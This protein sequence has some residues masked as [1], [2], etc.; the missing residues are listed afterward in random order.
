[1]SEINKGPEFWMSLEHADAINSGDA[2]QLSAFANRAESEFLSS[3][4]ASEDGKDGFARRE[5]LKLMGASIALATTACVRRPVQHIIPYAKAPKDVT[6]GV[7]NLYA[8]TWYDGIEGYGAIVRTLEGRPIKMEGNPLHPMNLGAFPARGHAE[9]LSLYD[10]DRLT[11]PVRNL[12]NKT[13]SNRE[14]ISGA[15]ADIDTKIAAALGKGSVAIL[16]STLPSP[17]TRAIISDFS[18]VFPGTRWVQYDTL[19]MDSVRE[20][21][22]L[23]YGRAVVPRYRLDQAKMIVSIDADILGSYLSPV[24][25]MKQWAKIRKP[26]PDQARFVM[27]DS[28]MSLSGMNADDRV[29]IKPS[30]QLDVVMGLL[31][32][33]SRIG[34]G[35]GIP[36]AAATYLKGFSGVATQLGMEPELFTKIA[37]QLWDNR[38][39]SLVIAGG[40]PTQTEN[41]VDLQVAVNLLNS[42]LGN[43]GKTIDHDSANYMTREGSAQDLA[44]LIADMAAGKIKTLIIHNLN[45]VYSLPKDSGFVEAIAKV[46]TVISTANRNDET[47]KYANFVLPNGSTL[48]SWGDYELQAGVY[49]IQQPT[50]RPLHD[51]RSFDESMFAWVKAA[52]GAP[53]RVASSETWMDYVKGV[54]RTEILPKAGKGTGDEAWF[55]VL[56]TGVVV[57]GNR[58]RGGSARGFSAGS[59]N[60]KARKAAS[61]YELV[62]YP[63]SQIGD[64]RYANVAW[65]Q[66]MPDPV[67]KIVWDNYVSIAP[68]TADKE[69]LKQGDVVEL[70]V[71]DKK[72]R[73]PVHVQPGQ[74]EDVFA[75]AIGYGRTDAGR[76]ASGLGVNALD[77]VSFGAGK[78][79]YSG[80]PVTFKKTGERYRL[81]STQDHH[82]LTPD[83]ASRQLVAE[84]T[85]TAYQK[86]PGSG[87][88][89]HKVFSI[90]PS[91]QYSKHKWAMSIDLNTCTGCS[92]CVVAC[93]S[94]N[95]VPVVGKKYVMEGREMHWLRIDRYY[96]GSVNAPEAVFQ[97][98]L[99]QHCE[100][101]PCETVCPVLATV[102]NDEG[103]NDMVYNR[104]VGTRYCSNNC[105]YKV[106]RFNWFNYSKREAPMHMALNPD[107]TVRTRG[108]MEKCTFCVHRIREATRAGV[109][110]RKGGPLKDGH[111]KT[112]CQETCPADAIVFGDLNDKESAVAKLFADQRTYGLLEDLNTAPRVRYMSRVRNADR[113][114]VDSHAT[115]ENEEH[116]AEHKQPAGQG[117]SHSERAGGGETHSAEQN[118]AGATAAGKSET[119]KQPEHAAEGGH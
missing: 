103:L 93:Q 13:R 84:T 7:Q 74:H 38:G 81:V 94:E 61:G 14:T 110:T 10:P 62:L 98:M 2:A 51:S 25:F 31:A 30:Q 75:L 88:H 40:L 58:D 106:R 92:A 29:R 91:H 72:V 1:M 87:I 47:A 50:I 102:H 8:S 89:R 112:A 27:F 18:R 3:P 53:A 108:V 107:V 86:N 11:G 119:N 117:E 90:W 78:Q 42:V 99:C 63:K 39:A 77:L 35:A 76:V 97:P 66:E 70:K 43:D 16:S 83:I 111:L 45:P 79:V 21:Q 64:G 96:K 59:F 41:A 73:A 85:N 44:T 48:E 55:S 109:E 9:V 95:N 116:A 115:G 46:E 57:T 101:A 32:E 114:I 71:G 20:A 104:C 80:L 56:Q 100:N 4:H 82:V 34:K 37:Q 105:P 69:G 12:Q 65:M 17:S 33:I 26:G 28:M 49:S 36:A 19:G 6:P 68:A 23:S 60:P 15:W 24:E 54:W 113:A 67:T 5:F 52:K 22:R 118:A